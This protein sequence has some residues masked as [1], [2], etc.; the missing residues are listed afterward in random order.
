MLS[1]VKA[2]YA[3]DSIPG[4]STRRAAEMRPFLFGG[5]DELQSAA[6]R[7]CRSLNAPWRGWSVQCGI[8]Q[9]C[10]AFSTSELH[11]GLAWRGR[12]RNQTSTPAR[13]VVPDVYLLQTRVLLESVSGFGGRSRMVAGPSSGVSW[14]APTVFWS[15]GHSGSARTIPE[16]DQ[17]PRHL[18]R[19]R[20]VGGA[21]DESRPGTSG[22]PQR[23][24]E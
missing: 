3:P 1:H 10:A 11:P 7:W 2:F 18:Q 14:C 8:A 4:S 24:R 23:S 6:S 13:V 15:A 5:A 17:R 19:R 16:W 21:S 12:Q 9:G 20:R 22:T